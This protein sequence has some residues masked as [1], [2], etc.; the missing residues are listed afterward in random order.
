MKNSK[1]LALLL[2]LTT[3]LT[4][5]VYAK[6]TYGPKTESI[7]KVYESGTFQMKATMQ[8]D[9]E[10]VELEMYV[11]NNMIAMIMS[12]GSERMRIVQRDTKSYMINDHDRQ[13][14]IA[15]VEAEAVHGV[16]DTEEIRF[17][18]SGTANFN[19]KNQ[20]YEEYLSDSDRMLFFIDGS[21]LTG[22]RTIA[23]E[24]G[25]VDMVVHSFDNFVPEIAFQIP[26]G[27]EI[28]D[29]TE[30]KDNEDFLKIF[31]E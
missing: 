29:L 2:I 8:A 19:G 11:K 6:S 25:T 7:M 30:F 26:T 12:S 21:R 5:L 10:S 22:I 18:N 20:T 15:P 16:I 27:Y 23:A 1:K 31:G 28:H 9:G 17:I 13:I 24:V 14:V 3:L 4:G